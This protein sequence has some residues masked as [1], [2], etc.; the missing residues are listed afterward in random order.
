MFHYQATDLAETLQLANIAL[1][2]A[3]K[4]TPVEYHKYFQSGIHF[5]KLSGQYEWYWTLR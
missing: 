1:N 3:R 4:A 5:C 2:V